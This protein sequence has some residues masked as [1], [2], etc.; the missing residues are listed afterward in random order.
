MIIAWQSYLGEYLHR[1]DECGVEFHGRKNQRYCN[2]K[3]KAK[4]NNELAADRRSSEKE[5]T[6]I[7]LRNIEIIL[8]ELDGE[9]NEVVMISMEKLL[10]YGFNEEGPNIRIQVAGVVWYKIGPVAYRPLE[11]SNEVELLKLDENESYLRD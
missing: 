11:E 8:A 2:L 9:E 5:R 3:C 4:R 6:D 1:C 7:Y 10:A